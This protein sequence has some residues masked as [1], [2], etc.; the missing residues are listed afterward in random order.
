MYCLICSVSIPE[1]TQYAPPQHAV[2]KG[3]PFLVNSASVIDFRGTRI[4]VFRMH[5]GHTPGKRTKGSR[6]ISPTR[7]SGLLDRIG[8][9]RGS[10]GLIVKI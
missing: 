3:I 10:G 7:F 1:A 5:L 4:N 6:L 8:S 9:S 2:L